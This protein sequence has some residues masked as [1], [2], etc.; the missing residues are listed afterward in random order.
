MLVEVDDG[1]VFVDQPNRAV[2][3]LRLRDPV[4]NR[5]TSH[6]RLLIDTR[7]TEL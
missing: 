2:T 7:A 5:I 1:M 4:A 3:V 6:V